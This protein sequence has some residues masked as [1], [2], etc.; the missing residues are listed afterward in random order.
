MSFGLPEDVEL[1][2]KTNSKMSGVIADSIREKEMN[3]KKRKVR[4]G[5]NR[6]SR[7]YNEDKDF[8]TFRELETDDFLE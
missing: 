1:I 4:R 8:N 6:L 7:F 2:L 3:E 5:A